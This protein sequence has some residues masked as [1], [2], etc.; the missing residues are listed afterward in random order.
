MPPQPPHTAQ[1]EPQGV[2]P[3]GQGICGNS[4]T[5]SKHTRWV[6]SECQLFS[7]SF[8]LF[9]KGSVWIYLGKYS[10]FAFHRSGCLSGSSENCPPAVSA[11]ESWCGGSGGSNLPAP[12]AVRMKAESG[13]DSSTS[14]CCQCADLEDGVGLTTTAEIP[15][16]SQP[17]RHVPT[18]WECKCMLTGTYL[19]RCL[20]NYHVSIPLRLCIYK[21]VVILQ[22]Q[23]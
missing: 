9:L 23:H 14:Y 4:S 19:V 17:V 7:S 18:A 6:C 10:M 5:D 13:G 11:R 15:F 20:S 2:C 22:T 1:K 16:A 8:L 12:A 3:R 21:T